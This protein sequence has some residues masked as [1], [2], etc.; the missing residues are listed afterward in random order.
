MEAQFEYKGVTYLHSDRKWDVKTNRH[1]STAGNR[2]GWIE[3]LAG[4]VCWSNDPGDRLSGKDATEIVRI[5]NAWIDDQV[6]VS[7]K[8]V[9]ASENLARAERECSDAEIRFLDAEAVLEK[10][11]SEVE[12]LE[13]LQQVT[14]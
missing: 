6:P 7:L 8:L 9:K 1:T 2:W 10:A 13:A 3:G 11:R 12:R 14:V 5:H 4:N